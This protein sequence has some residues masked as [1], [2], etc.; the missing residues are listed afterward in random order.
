MPQN[1]SLFNT[2][3]RGLQCPP[4]ETIGT[5]L[6]KIGNVVLGRL[7]TAL[8]SAVTSRLFSAGGLQLRHGSKL[9]SE[10]TTRHVEDIL[11]A[12]LTS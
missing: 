6:D 5:A 3:F 12:S 7:Q 8:I 2:F 11:K 1:F 9:P 4:R 10:G